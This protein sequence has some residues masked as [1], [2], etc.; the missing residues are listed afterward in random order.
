[1]KSTHALSLLAGLGAFI[2]LVA[3]GCGSKETRIFDDPGGN[4]EGGFGF[5]DGGDA[6]KAC[7]GRQCD[8]VECGGGVE[9]TL[10]GK[11]Y[12]PNGRLPLYNAIV[13]VPNSQP[14]ELVKGATCDKCGAVTGDPVVT[15]LTDATG[16]FELRNVPVGKD[17]PLVIQIGKWRRQVVIPEI[18]RCTENK[19]SDPE[20]TRLPKSQSEG[21]MPQIALTTGG[22]DK[23]GCMLP[24]VGI[25]PSE[26]GVEGDGPSKAV[27]VYLGSAGFG[28]PTAGPPGAALAETLWQDT[29]KMMNYD[30]L[31]LS[32]EC[33]ESLQNKGGSVNGPAFG[34]VTDYL[35]GGG[36]IFTTDFMYTWYRYSPDADFKSA[37]NLRG[38]APGGGS[39]MTID[40]S[41]PKGQALSDWL[42]SAANVVGGR[43]T[44]D[45]MYGNV[46]SIDPAKSQ[47]WASSGT[48]NAGPRVFSVNVPVGVPA[49][50]QCGKGV[51]IDAHVNNDFNDDVNAQ[52]PASCKT[53][54]KPAESLLA[55]F[56]FDL[57]S[58]IQNE[59]EPPKPPPV[60]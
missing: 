38:G 14:E 52:Y 29:T 42:A 9:T 25:D 50:Q 22:C 35:K 31:I 26:F 34:A 45:A 60:K 7:V 30:M 49:D 51:H 44:P 10:T 23:L 27:H 24:K 54:M 46:I 56:F 58:C 36:R 37:T 5:A 59:G 12:A 40:T 18:D 32:C 28:G 19:V 16:S 3:I 48:P 1:M 15:A 2:G 6:K 55:F 4:D 47:H 8:Q 53:P 17:V 41:F 11:V 57:A 20:L 21:D 33:T 43:V 39:P 13:Y